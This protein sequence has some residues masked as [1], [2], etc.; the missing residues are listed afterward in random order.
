VR[1]WL[2]YYEKSRLDEEVIGSYE[3]EYAVAWF[4]SLHCD[5]GRSTTW[6]ISFVGAGVAELF[7]VDL[8]RTPF[9]IQFIDVFSL[10][11]T[12][13][14]N[15]LIL[16]EA[17]DPGGSNWDFVDKRVIMTQAGEILSSELKIDGQWVG[18]S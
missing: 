13:D 12:N 7:Y 6:Q 8:M 3:T 9:K 4:S 18:E 11:L 14:D 1:Y 15:L 16:G 5:G 10:E 2:R 17:Y